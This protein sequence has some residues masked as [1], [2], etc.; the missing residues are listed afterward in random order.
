MHNTSLSYKTECASEYYGSIMVNK[1]CA[2]KGKTVFNPLCR[3]DRQFA[4][5]KKKTIKK[6]I[7]SL[8]PASPDSV[9]VLFLAFVC[10][11]VSNFLGLILKNA[12][13]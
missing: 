10:Q 12:L 7:K 6:K 8:L 3:F 13:L 2:N 11:V 1:S 5:L 9:S 4:L